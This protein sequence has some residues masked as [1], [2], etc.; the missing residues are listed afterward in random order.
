MLFRVLP[1]VS[2]NDSLKSSCYLGAFCVSS[3]LAMGGLAA[4]WG[5]LTSRVGSSE[6][7]Q[8]WL[9][10]VSSS[11]SVVVGAFWMVLVMTG[12]MNDLIG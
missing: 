7:V 3:I 8:F 5:E 4:L 6:T 10:F 2:M 11:S 12:K 9:I 1:A